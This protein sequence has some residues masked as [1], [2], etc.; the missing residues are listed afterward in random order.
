MLMA[1]TVTT[2]AQLKVDSQGKT[3]M[4]YTSSYYPLYPYVPTACANA[5]GQ[6]V[7]NYGIVGSAFES[8]SEAAS[9]M[10]VLGFAG[11]LTTGRNYGVYGG[12]RGTENGAGIYGSTTISYSTPMTGRYAGY[13]KGDTYCNGTL[14]ATNVVT[15]SDT[16]LKENI[17]PVCKAV[18]KG[19]T[20]QNV[21]DMNIVE[22]NFRFSPQLEEFLKTPKA[23]E[24]SEEELEALIK[25]EKLKQAQRHI[26]LLAQELQSTYPQLVYEGQDG[27][28]GVNYLEL[29]PVLIRAIQELKQELDEVKGGAD[30]TKKTRSD[31][32]AINTSSIAFTSNVL[33]QNTPNP[34]KEKTIIRFSLAPNAQNA[35]I[36]IFD[37]SGKMLKTLPVSPNDT[38]VSVNGYEL[39]EGMFLYSLLVNGQEIDTKRMI[40]TK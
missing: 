2:T 24:I 1:G 38:S 39:G 11:N 30:E 23:K 15:T 9:N 4:G 27:Y 25:E 33:Y 28:L 35:S 7:C 36:C 12:L 16:R 19:T 21:L 10:G 20:L 31:A 17:M 18:P 8:S 3:N 37:M 34:F 5:S 22:Y 32:T 40:I 6:E 14:T 13:F 26:G 29:V